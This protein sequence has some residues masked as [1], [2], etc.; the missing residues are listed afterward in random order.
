MARLGA[1]TDGPPPADPDG[2]SVPSVDGPKSQAEPGGWRGMVGAAVS[3]AFAVAVVCGGKWA[4]T[5]FT[6]RKLDPPNP[7]LKSL[8]TPSSSKAGGAD[9][10]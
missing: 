6:A 7:S 8:L 4:V 3:I 5:P 9:S 10:A 1:T 2:R